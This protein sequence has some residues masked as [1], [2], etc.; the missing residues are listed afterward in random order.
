MN[1]RSRPSGGPGL[2]IK[3]GHDDRVMPRTIYIDA[4][5][6]PMREEIY[7]V[8]KRYGLLTYVVANQWMGMPN[9]PAIRLEVVNDDFDAADDWIVD[10]VRPGDIVITD[11]IPLAKRVITQGARTLTNRGEERTASSI[12]EALAMREL[13]QYLRDVG[14]GTR[15]KPITQADR[16][17]FKQALDR[18]IAAV[19]SA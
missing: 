15:H 14:E 11:D 19:P 12:G 3:A 18:I 10:R 17:A 9:D 6:C 2:P 5:A 1:G 8:A 16:R 13:M 4:D 7:A